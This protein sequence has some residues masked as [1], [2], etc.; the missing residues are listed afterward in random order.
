LINLEFHILP[1]TQTPEFYDIGS[2]LG[3]TYVRS[4]SDTPLSTG[5]AIRASGSNA[6][7]AFTGDLNHDHS[8]LSSILSEEGVIVITNKLYQ[9]NCTTGRV[10]VLT[11]VVA[12]RWAPDG[13][14][15]FLEFLEALLYTL[16]TSSHEKIVDVRKSFKQ[17]V[18]SAVEARLYPPRQ[19]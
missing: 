12:R 5:D 4:L 6:V 18:R 2:F 16:S 7:S 9:R 1:V 11:R 17:R 13:V 8:T 10:K 15:V 3:I 19:R 14:L